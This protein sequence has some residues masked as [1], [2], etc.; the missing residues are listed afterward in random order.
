M[1]TTIA[2]SLSPWWP[3]CFATDHE[4]IL[5]WLN[6]IDRGQIWDGLAAATVN[7]GLDAPTSAPTITTPIGG[8]AT[9]GTYLCYYRFK[10]ALGRY[11]NLSPVASTVAAANDK[12]SWDTIPAS[13]D[14]RVTHKDLLRTV[15]NDTGDD[16]VEYIITT[17]TNATTSFTTDTAS[18]AT[19][20]ATTAYPIQNADGYTLL[21]R[22]TPPLASKSVA[23]M[24]YDRMWYLVE[25]PYF[26]GH[27]EVTN[28]SAAITGRGTAWTTPMVNRKIYFPGDT[29]EYNVD[30]RG[31]ATAIT[32][33]ANFGGTT[34]IFQPYCIR[35][36]R[37]ERRKVYYS[38]AVEAESVP[39]TNNLYIQEQQNP[40]D[41]ITGAMPLRN[42]LFVLSEYHIHRI[43]MSNQGD[44]VCAVAQ[45]VASR[46]AINHRCWAAVEGTGYLLDGLGLHRFSEA[47]GDKHISTPYQDLWN[48]TYRTPG[49]FKLN[50]ASSKWW[51]ASVDY[52][53]ELVRF[54]V[55]LGNWYLPQ[56]AICLAY[57]T[58]ATW[59]EDFP[60]G[61][62]GFAMVNMNGA[63]R[64]VFGGEYGGFRVQDGLKDGPSVRSV[65][66]T[67][68][69]GT[70]YTLTDTSSDA[71]IPSAN[72]VNCNVAIVEGTGKGQE[73]RAVISASGTVTLKNKF[74]IQPDTT[75][76][77]QIGGASYRVM[78][79]RMEWME[80]DGN[81][82]R[83][84]SILANPTTN[85]A[86]INLRR[87]TDQ[88]EVAE[89]YKQA[90]SIGDGWT[91][92]GTDLAPD[93]DQ[94]ATLKRTQTQGKC[95]GFR[96]MR[97]DGRLSNRA[98]QERF[99]QLELRGV[100]GDD[101]II[102]RE[103]RVSGVVEAG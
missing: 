44:C 57:R 103:I 37:D 29:S 17:I 19:I 48:T 39:S 90:G 1:P 69:A 100:Q 14:A 2:S 22:F 41:E 8:A 60:W 32:L 30:A 77:Y 78:L 79:P 50:F 58:G 3:A 34:S 65:R 102:L 28:A 87:F 26:Q 20:S 67:A 54:H 75:S 81:Y 74:L 51:F 56:H 12:F 4:N 66:G 47:E 80:S 63:M 93:P 23:V 64:P 86:T 92:S 42:F 82:E 13:T 7:L 38:R 99:V 62:G 43:T 24:F 46:G 33:G 97:F 101:P 15:A 61:M 55:S 40:S 25:V 9:A 16:A 21:N 94:S 27:C 95:S 53:R 72:V 31:S 88:Q 59:V 73:R 36:A 84:V 18:D 98:A 10:D 76:V 35:S 96:A 89:G 68:T 6:G 5:Y 11:S 49:S 52:T 70:M 83:Q 45:F 85:D 71:E 91:T